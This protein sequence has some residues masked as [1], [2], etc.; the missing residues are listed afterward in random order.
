LL[1]DQS[2]E[3]SAREEREREREGESERERERA[4]WLKPLSGVPRIE[5]P[6]KTIRVLKGI[7]TF[8]LV[9]I[10]T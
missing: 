7:F 9:I 1:S 4:S 8:D 2:I 6:T 3:I 10:L 5:K